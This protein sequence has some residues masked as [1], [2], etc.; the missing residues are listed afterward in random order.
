MAEN[1][2]G[3]G[4]KKKPASKKK[5]TRKKATTVSAGADKASRDSIES[6]AKPVTESAAIV[7]PSAAPPAAQGIPAG[8]STFR[9]GNGV[10]WFA[11]L[12]SLVAMGAGGYAWYLTAVDSKLS[13]GQSENRYEMMNQRVSGFELQQTDLG[14]QIAQLKIRLSQADTE[15]T[16]RIRSIRNELEFQ[17]AA[18]SEQIKVS[19]ESV[20]SQADSFKTDFSTLADSIEIMRSQ[21]G[22]S[23][24]SWTLEEVEQLL[25]VAQQR[26]EFS[27]ET[28]LAVKALQL[29]DARLEQLADPALSALRKQIAADISALEGVVKE[30]GVGLLN[31]LALLSEE[32]YKLPLAGD[33][34]SDSFD[35]TSSSASVD[36]TAGEANSQPADQGALDSIVQPV[37]DAAAAFMESLGDLIQVEK[38]GKS[39][40]PVVSDHVRQLTYERARLYLEAAQIAYVRKDAALYEN[41]IQS[42]HQ[43]VEQNFDTGSADTAQWLTRLSEIPSSYTVPVVPEISGSLEAMRQVMDARL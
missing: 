39:L 12:L 24:D 36:S 40:K 13:M 17:Q 25:F 23:L 21:L 32:V 9:G 35:S 34:S 37:S 38:N 4:G 18:V 42:V 19:T 27:G 3:A 41:R 28:E 33:F 14:A 29:A 20:Q 15:I 11:L 8:S 10:S 5:T 7:T 30:D 6:E 43:W 31:N 2:T 16:E 1:K 26:V 22:K